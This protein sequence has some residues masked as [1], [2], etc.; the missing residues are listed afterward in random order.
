MFGANLFT[1]ENPEKSFVNVKIQSLFIYFFLSIIPTLFGIILE[2]KCKCTYHL[3]KDQLS[4]TSGFQ[5]YTRIAT[6]CVIDG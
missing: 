4:L 3:R 5:K 1:V 6:W 2:N